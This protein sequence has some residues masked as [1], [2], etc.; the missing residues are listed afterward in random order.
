MPARQFRKFSAALDQLL[1]RAGFDDL[2]TLEHQDPGCLADGREPM[3]DHERGAPAH[4]LVQCPQQLGFG[5]RVERARGLVEDEDRRILEQRASNRQALTLAAGQPA[6]AFADAGMKPA[7][8]REDEIQRLRPL[9]CP[10]HLL[11]RRI[12][13]ADAQILRDRSVEQQTLLE[14][15][16][17][18]AAQCRKLEGADVAAVDLDRARLRIEAAVQ[19]RQRRGL[20]RAGRADERDGLSRCRG[21]V[22]PKHRGRFAPVGKRHVL[23]CDQAL[24]ATGIHRV[25]TV[26]DRRDGVAHLEELLQLRRFHE[27]PIGESDRVLQAIDQHGGEAHEGDDLADRSQPLREQP[28]AEQDDRQNGDRGRRPGQHRDHSPP[29]QHRDLRREQLVDDGFEFR[30]FGL[31]ASE[32]VDQR[33]VAER[34]GRAFGE[35]GIMLL[36]RALHRLGLAQHECRQSGKHR[37]QRHQ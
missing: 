16:A 9:G 31:D 32:T 6:S 20:A 21:E 24:H 23:E 36:D 10:P 34:V 3:R 5:C 8:P 17:D 15:H 12:G 33:H 19:Q 22:Q 18:I 13:P 29:R 35:L 4:D 30:D 1:E 37:A 26:A 27:H 25:R 11:F 14:H 28:G 7:L 2:P